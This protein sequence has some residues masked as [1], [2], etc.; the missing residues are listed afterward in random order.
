MRRFK[1]PDQA[2]RFLGPFS[3][4]GD[5]FRVGRFRSPAPARRLLLSERSRTWREVVLAA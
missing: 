4:I 1:S 3:A 5:H 2:Q